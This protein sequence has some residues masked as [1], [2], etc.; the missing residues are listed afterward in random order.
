M[1]T[2]VGC[3]LWLLWKI[4]I[5]CLSLLNHRLKVSRS[6]SLKQFQP[7]TIITKHREK[8]YFNAIHSV[9]EYYN[10]VLFHKYKTFMNNFNFGGDKVKVYV[11]NY[12]EVIKFTLIFLRIKSVVL[13]P[14]PTPQN[15]IP[16]THPPIRPQTV[17]QFCPVHDIFPQP[18]I[19]NRCP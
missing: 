17:F 3:E 10:G 15:L 12:Y 18:K 13:L 8:Q 2:S 16:V 14:P 6:T 4:I 1:Y 19:F 9:F 5:S 7:L 11:P